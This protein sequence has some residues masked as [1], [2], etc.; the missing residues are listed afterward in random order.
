MIIIYLLL[1]VFLF[2]FAAIFLILISTRIIET[3]TT[4]APFVSVPDNIE[5]DIVKNLKLTTGSVLYDLGCGD[6]RI[7]K[8]ALDSQPNMRAVGIEI[9]FLPYL[10]A[11][12]FTRK[13]KQIEIK[14][15]DIFQTDIKD[16]THIFLYLYTP[17][18]SKLIN[19]IKDQCRPGTRIVSCDFEIQ[20]CVPIEIIDLKNKRSRLGQKLLVYE[21]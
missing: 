4:D 5:N 3:F 16:A 7:L 18:V 13:Y 19:N 15:E 1:S 21:I 20:S 6:A 9:A 2:I 8:R 14:R 10:L 11:K 17:V 12:F